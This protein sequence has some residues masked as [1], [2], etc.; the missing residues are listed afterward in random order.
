MRLSN[1]LGKTLRE[2]PSEAATISE[3]LLVRGGFIKKLSS[4]L[5]NYL[6]LGWCVLKKI[7]QIIRD[8]MNL[9]DGQEMY[10]PAL[11][12]KSLWEETGRWDEIDVLFKLKDHKESEFLLAPTAEETVTD[13]ARNDVT[14][15]KQLPFM[16]YQFQTKFRDEPRARGGLLRLKQF[17]MKDAYSFHADFADLDG[18]YLKVK[19]AYEN[20]YKR[21]GL[22]AM[23]VEADVGAMGGS[24][25]H[26][27]MAPSEIGEDDI[28][29]CENCHYV[30][31]VEKAECK[32]KPQENEDKEELA[33]IEAAT[34]DKKTIEEVAKFLSVDTTKT[35][36]AMFYMVDDHFVFV[37]VR[38]DIE[39]NEVKLLN[40]LKA[41]KLRLATPEE[42]KEVGFV[43]GY[44]SPIGVSNV[45]V[46]AD[47]SVRIGNNFIVGANKEGYHFKNANFSRDF[48]VS[49]VVDVSLCKEGSLCPHCDRT[50]KHLKGIEVGHIFK[51]GTRYSKAMGLEF[52]TANE[53]KESVIM[54]SYGIGL[55]RLMA[56]IV[57][58]NH[59][60]QG[61]IWSKNVAPFAAHL[62]AIGKD[63]KVFEKA[64]ESYEQLQDSGVDVLFD[65]RRDKTAGEKF[66]DVDLI[67]I[68]LR[69]LFSE[70][71]LAQNSVELKKRSEKDSQLVLIKDLIG[72]LTSHE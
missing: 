63:E 7:E 2:A 38:G 43:S 18:Y 57:E 29:I 66:A 54:G 13:I 45:R 19:Q 64:N 48:K 53:K 14:S 69:V 68:P 61:I 8:E 1:L 40:A 9:I 60:E 71:T 24:A 21:C 67:G 62:V 55:E 51:L 23:A 3:Q 41:K 36:K 56:T 49:D 32:I 42:V 4:G 11:Q 22:D 39:I 12:P 59:N 26:E 50:L 17:I 34:P 10:M 58:Q 16:V 47:Q 31:N 5:Y 35:I 30:A 33:L 6:P 70:K 15:Y 27:F 28:M 37:I 52:L 46:V 25:S 20:I 44:A 65:D 72:T